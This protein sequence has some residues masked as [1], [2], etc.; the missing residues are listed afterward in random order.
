MS[1]EADFWQ[2][3]ARKGLSR[4]PFFRRSLNV[5]DLDRQFLGSLLEPQWQCLKLQMT[6]GDKLWPFEFHVR[7][8]LGLRRGIILMRGAE[9]VGGIV[10]EVS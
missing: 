3:A 10:T 1:T 8:F 7:P 2:K 6:P 4:F 9:A 5:A